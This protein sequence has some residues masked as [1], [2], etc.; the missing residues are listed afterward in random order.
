MIV[1]RIE[2][3]DVCTKHNTCYLR[4]KCSM[5]RKCGIIAVIIIITFVIR[6]DL[7]HLGNH[8]SVAIMQMTLASHLIIQY[9]SLLIYVM[10]PNPGEGEQRHH[11]VA[12][13]WDG[14]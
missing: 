6:L 11:R 5:N 1:L 7:E 4:P 13:L 8:S 3:D 9:F 10:M 14:G 2:L 12:G